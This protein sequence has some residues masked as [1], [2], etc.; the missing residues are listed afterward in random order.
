MTSKNANQ[1]SGKKNKLKID[2]K[3]VT[4]EEFNAHYT[5][6]LSGQKFD[7]YGSRLSEDGTRVIGGL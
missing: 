1:V 7:G 6:E 2:G 3:E 5:Q 4:K